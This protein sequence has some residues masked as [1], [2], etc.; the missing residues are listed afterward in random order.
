MAVLLVGYDVEAYGRP[1][2]TRSFLREAVQLHRELDAPCTMFL[3]GRVVEENA[4]YILPLVGD[5]LFD[6]QQHTYSHKLL[7]TVCME[8]NKGRITIWHG[9]SPAEVEEDVARA[10]EVMVKLLGVDPIGLCGPYN[11]YRGLSDRPDLLEILHRNGIR[12][13]RTYGRNEKDYQPTPFSAQPF[14]YAPQ[15]FPD[16]LEIPLQGYQDLYLREA[17]G[18]E[19]TDAYIQRVLRQLEAVA[20]R[21]L[22]WSYCQHDHSNRGDPHMSI[23]R[24]LLT[25]AKQLGVELMT[26]KEFYDR[27]LP[28]CG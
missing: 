20:E 14:W 19:N 27:T 7:K 2:V 21:N 6:L 24:A 23:V 10:R 4:P 22:V 9:A 13:T 26:H 16:I 28:A 8:H 18:W 11:Y 15:G 3:V 25:R 1:E 17:Y 5:P 12:F